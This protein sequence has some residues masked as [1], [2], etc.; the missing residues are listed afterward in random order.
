[1]DFADCIILLLLSL[2]L[3]ERSMAGIHSGNLYLRLSIRLCRD[4]VLHWLRKS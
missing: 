3:S 2:S 1:M 4:A